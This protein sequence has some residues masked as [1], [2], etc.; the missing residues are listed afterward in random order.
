MSEEEAISFIKVSFNSN[1][2]KITLK[3]ENLDD[4]REKRER[5]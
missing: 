4:F 1:F 2:S 3:V 5:F